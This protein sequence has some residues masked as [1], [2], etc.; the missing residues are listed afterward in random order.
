MSI[1]EQTYVNGTSTNNFNGLCDFSY[2]YGYCLVTVCTYRQ[3]GKPVKA[4]NSTGVVGYPIAGK[5][6]SY[7]GLCAFNCN[8][9]YCLS[10]AYGTE[11]VPLIIPTTSDFVPPIYIVGTRSGALI[12]LCSFAYNYSF[13][14]I[15]IYKCTTQGGLVP[16][17]ATTNT[18][19]TPV[20][21][22]EDHRLCNFAYSHGYCP[23]GTYVE[24]SNTSSSEVF[25]SPDI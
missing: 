8:L 13:C 18:K 7:S 10:L 3:I 20:K 25:F 15:Y 4:P 22:L 9:G 19:G 23:K 1:S 12:G 24:S 16:A 17:P 11:E 2:S 6:V 21:G 14:P 5:D